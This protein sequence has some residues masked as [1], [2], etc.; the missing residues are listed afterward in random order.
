MELTWHVPGYRA[1][2]R[3]D[4]EVGGT[5]VLAVRTGTGEHV[6]VHEPVADPPAGIARLVGLRA[7]N[8]VAILDVV[9]VPSG[10]V[11]VTELVDGVSLAATLERHGPL[12]PE[13]TL[14]LLTDAA[15][16]MV[17]VRRSGAVGH[18]G[19]AR[20]VLVTMHGTVRLAAHT[21]G[22]TDL[23]ALLAASAGPAVPGLLAAA[24]RP[25]RRSAAVVGRIA[26]SSY[27]VDWEE[28]G[29]RGLRRRAALLP[30]LSPAATRD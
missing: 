20:E 10:I 15:R 21:A 22:G 19:T 12:E 30:A 26:E 11:I 7:P 16:A 8:L 3:L 1:V 23:A 14:C 17:A 13:S 5:A 28:R 25:T 29:R 18:R 24:Q 2:R 27:G 6:V 9:E 4:R